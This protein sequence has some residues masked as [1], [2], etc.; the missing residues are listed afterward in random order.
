V[1]TSRLLIVEHYITHRQALSIELG[2]RLLIWFSYLT[3]CVPLSFKGGGEDIEKRGF[4][5][6]K[7]PF[8]A[9]DR[10]RVYD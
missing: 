5:P 10:A 9:L 3:P 6:L 8:W 1:L 7:L 4:A 2:G